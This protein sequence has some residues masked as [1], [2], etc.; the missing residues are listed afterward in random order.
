[1]RSLSGVSQS[2]SFTTGYAGDDDRVTRLS[3]I[4][5]R[6]A[7]GY[8][9]STA[10]VQTFST[11]NTGE[12]LTPRATATLSDGKFDVLQEARFHVARF[13]LTGDVRVIGLGA[14][15]TPTGTR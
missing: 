5:L 3:K 9:P 6:F 13:D 1:M 11:M 4:R 14:E 8:A 15:L 12:A 10:Q 7:P 2:S